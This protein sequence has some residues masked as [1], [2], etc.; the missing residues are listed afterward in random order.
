MEMYVLSRILETTCSLM[1]SE[2]HTK[3]AGIDHF[4]FYK[5]Q[6]IAEA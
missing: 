5:L 3:I 1:N 2:H 4:I 6:Q